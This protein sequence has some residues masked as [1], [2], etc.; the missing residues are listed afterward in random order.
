[1]DWV[2]LIVVGVFFLSFMGGVVSGFLRV[3]WAVLFIVGMFSISFLGGVIY[4]LWYSN[5]YKKPSMSRTQVSLEIDERI[6]Y[7]S[8]IAS[9]TE[10]YV[11]SSFLMLSGFVLGFTIYLLFFLFTGFPARGLG[12][13]MLLSVILTAAGGVLGVVFSLTEQLVIRDSSGTKHV[14][15][16]NDFERLE[17]KQELTKDI[18]K[19]HK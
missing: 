18:W 8:H 3:E 13:N 15:R 16:L 1:M 14:L 17:L 10:E 19:M 9:V 5:F 12:E 7:L 11:Y 4:R 6:I 2:V